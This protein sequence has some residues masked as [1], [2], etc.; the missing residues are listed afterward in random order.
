MKTLAIVLLAL[1]L[2]AAAAGLWLQQQEIVGLR[3]QV[4]SAQGEVARH[5]AARDALEK[6]ARE[7]QDATVALQE[8]LQAQ[9]QAANKAAKKTT[10]ASG[11]ATVMS[12]ETLKQWLADADD[13]DVMRRLTL[14]A[15]G[16]TQQ[17]Y[18][19]LFKQLH[20]T[21]EQT[22]Q[23]AKLLTDKRQTSI[24]VAVASYRRGE[25]PTKEPERYRDTLI[26]TR[27][28]IEAQI[29]LLLG[30]AA[31]TQYQDFDR[32]VGQSNVLNNLSLA[33]QGTADPLT[34]DQAARFTAA[35]Q[36]SN[37]NRISS[38]VIEAAKEFLSPAQLRAL[39]D[40]RAM[41]QANSQKRNQ[42]GQALPTTVAPP[43]P[44]P[45]P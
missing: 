29:S 16:K 24:D 10:R 30:D 44:A 34:P 26:A 7:A 8:E 20:L 13:P 22:E 3:N 40:L 19:E 39:Q 45:K 41:Q 14:Q 9:R 6:R 42:P 35:M 21:P 43:P 27:E 38:P 37:S 11:D 36:A 2:L 23:F 25:D 18:A 4:A 15:R 1:G 32:S 31:Y 12:A 33:L 28:E 5:A 17:R